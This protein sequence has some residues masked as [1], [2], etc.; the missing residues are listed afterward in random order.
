MIAEAYAI[1]SN[2]EL[3]ANYD[4][5]ELRNFEAFADK[6]EYARVEKKRIA[7]G[8][9]KILLDE[10]RLSEYALTLKKNLR[11]QRKLFNVDEFGRNRGGVPSRAGQ[12]VR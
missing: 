9:E 11:M 2:M 1:L 3:R 4:A 7:I 5:S 12:D 6:F 8:R 10:E